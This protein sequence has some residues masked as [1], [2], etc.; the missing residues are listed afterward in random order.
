MYYFLSVI[1]FSSILMSLPRLAACSRVRTLARRS[2]LISSRCP[3]RP[4]LKNTCNAET[5]TAWFSPFCLVY[6][7]QPVIDVQLLEAES[8][9]LLL[10]EVW[11]A[12]VCPNLYW[13]WSISSEA[14]SFS[15]AFLL[16]TNLSSGIAWGFRMR[17]LWIG[18]I[19][20]SWWFI[21]LSSKL[22]CNIVFTVVPG[23]TD[24]EKFVLF[25]NWLIIKLTS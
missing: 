7:V 12:L 23:L 10:A 9:N 5:Q 4:A 24:V 22:Y 19:S 8:K 15:A 16:S 21:S 6:R 17:Y 1:F 20:T 11:L 3:S 18:G 2:S 13:L 14:R 25:I